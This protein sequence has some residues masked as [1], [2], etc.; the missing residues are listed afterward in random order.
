MEANH[1]SPHAVMDDDLDDGFDSACSTDVELDNGLD[2]ES[3]PVQVPPAI[4]PQPPLC[5]VCH[6]RPPYAK[7]GKSYPTCGLTCAAKVSM[8]CVCKSRPSYS[9]GAKKY[10]TCGLECAAQ[11]ES[12]VGS[13][14][15]SPQTL[16]IVCKIRPSYSKGSKMYPTCG[17]TCAAKLVKLCDY[18]QKKPKVKGFPHCGIRCRN[19]AKNSCLMCRS[20]PKIGRYQFC[21]RT[22]RDNARKLAPLILEVPRGHTTF[23]MVERK[24]QKSWRVGQSPSIKKVYKI[25][26][27]ANFLISYD[28]YLKKYG[29]ECFRYHGT[30]RGCQLG[31][32][33]HT[34][35]CTSSSC[36][37][38]S[39]IKTSFQ[40]RFA[41]SGAFGSG[42]YTSSASNKSASYT[43][44]GIMFLNKVVLGNVYP[45][46]QFAAVSSCPPGYQ[47]VVFDRTNGSLNETVVY[48]NDAIRP[49]FL[50]VFG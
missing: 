6:T 34:T 11:L 14:G 10:P 31:D 2:G 19:M 50:I 9:N 22:C 48:T 17:L 16:C 23:D 37:V 38:C 1:S 7:E 47:S 13:Q 43:N 3:Q 36:A 44:S 41:K 5:I 12:R 20:S 24:F 4:P 35:L 33:G 18:C 30:H 28:N 26:E 21:G 8:C 25:V 45:V 32:D 40:V 29:N 46:S 39:I 27:K 42:V 49:V 15:R